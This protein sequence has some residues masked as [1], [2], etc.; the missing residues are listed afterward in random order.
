MEKME[1]HAAITPRALFFPAF[2]LN[3]IQPEIASFDQ[4]TPKTLP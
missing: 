4:S 2:L 3:L 1:L